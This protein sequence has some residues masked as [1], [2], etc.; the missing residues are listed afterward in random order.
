M[1]SGQW[2]GG[3]VGSIISPIADARA[4]RM[5]A[6]ETGPRVMNQAAPRDG[7]VVFLADARERGESGPRRNDV[8][9]EENPP[10]AQRRVIADR[11]RAAVA[12]DLGEYDGRAETLRQLRGQGDSCG[13]GRNDDVAR[14]RCHSRQ[15]PFCGHSEAEVFGGDSR[16]AC[17]EVGVSAAEK[18][19][20][21]DLER[22]GSRE[23]ACDSGWVAEP[24][25][26]LRAVER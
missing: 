20:V 1:Q 21:A 15:K 18:L 23:D 19:E 4:V 12:S 2:R 24:G 26:E 3:H 9:H 5:S 22:L 14:P 25:V 6:A 7:G 13:R 17:E 8:V 11:R 10:S 16:E